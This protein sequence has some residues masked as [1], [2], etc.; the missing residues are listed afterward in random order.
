MEVSKDYLQKR[1]IIVTIIISVIGIVMVF[2]GS[3]GLYAGRYHYIIFQS[4]WMVLGSIAGFI[5]YKV[6]YKL[7]QKYS[8]LLMILAIFLLF[9][10]IILSRKINGSTRWINLLNFA[11][12]QPSE[13]AKFAFI[14]YMSAWFVKRQNIIENIKTFNE[15]LKKLLLPFLAIT[16]FV[17]GLI[18]LE[19]DLGTTIIIILIA[20]FMLI[21]GDDSKYLKINLLISFLTFTFAG[22]LA[23]VIEPYRVQ[24]LLTYLSSSTSNSFLQG[25]GYQVHQIMIAIGSGGLLGVG[26]TQSVQKNQYLVGTTSITDSIFAVLAEEMGLIG[27]ILLILLYLY[28]V[29]LIFKV[30][31]RS[32]NPFGKFMV[33]GIGIWIGI[34]A[35]LNIAANIGIIPLTGIPLPLISYG[36]SSVIILLV[37]IGFVLNINKKT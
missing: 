29:Y 9:V 15:N 4:L 30:A 34:Q 16:A 14:T 6:D 36:G 28:L 8:F 37:A 3:L 26:F 25:A 23:I 21:L 31:I 18:V 2:D 17:A 1:I 32:G 24:R 20:L 13:F 33:A 10:V 7:F 5:I 35:M 22:I 19:K 27:S 11:N 12:F